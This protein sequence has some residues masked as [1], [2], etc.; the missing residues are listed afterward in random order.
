[1]SDRLFLAIET[2]GRVGS[3]GLALGRELL[4]VRRLSGQRPHTAELLP[5]IRDVLAE[6]RW[7]PADVG[8]FCYSCGPGSFTGL[9]VAATIG[10]ML[11]S[12][13]GCQV[14]AVPTLEVIARNALRD[15]HGPDRIV[16]LLDAKGGQVYAAAYERAAADGLRCVRDAGLYEPGELLS[17]IAPPFC[18]LGEGVRQ[19]AAACQ[20]SGGSVLE[21]DCWP[22]R[23]EEVLAIGRELAARGRICR[24][25]EIVPLYIRPPECEEVYEERRAAAR[26]RRGE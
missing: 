13:V 11:Q 18:I 1:M 21:E 10:R 7:R 15:P 23:V 26:R 17:G 20:A 25:E 14:V 5:A 4:A 16:P 12:V 3:V 2:S 19:H 24:P 8:V 22:P 6:S 9:R